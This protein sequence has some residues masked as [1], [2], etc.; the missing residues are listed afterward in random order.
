M[1][2]CKIGDGRVAIRPWS[3]ALVATAWAALAGSSRAEDVIEY[4]ND[5]GRLATARGTIG[6]ETPREVAIKTARGDQRIGVHRIDL[7][8]YDGQS[9][10]LGV[11]RDLERQGRYQEAHDQYK[12]QL[13]QVPEGKETLADAVAVAV[14]R[15]AC[16][17]AIADPE[18]AELPIKMFEK[19]GPQFKETRHYYPMQELI[20][21]VYL[22]A[23]QFDKAATAFAPL[24]EVTWPG[25][26]EKA[27]VY[28]GLAALK[29]KKLDDAKRA[30]E[31]VMSSASND[32]DVVLQ[33]R[34][35]QVYLGE[36]LV[37][38]K[39]T[40]EAEKLLREALAQIPTEEAELK[41]I[42]HNALGDALAANGKPK[43]AVL[44]GYLWVVTIYHRHPDQVARALF[45]LAQLFPRIGFAD[46]GREMSDRLKAEHPK[47]EWAR[48]LGG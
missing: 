47:S 22:A 18:K 2:R 1:S 17:A 33:K 10:Q 23:G 36:A 26:R 29:Q 37:E 13:G 32:R 28:Q 19:D 43:E 39:K 12:E 11:I 48:R 24:K 16:K 27:T 42:G 30:F 8:R 4:Y 6:E 35:A 46:H 21:Q 40:A 15:T 3:L 44:D 9:P 14:F 38:E 20:G 45:H 34:V 41:A 7:I 31:E 5:E 25:Y